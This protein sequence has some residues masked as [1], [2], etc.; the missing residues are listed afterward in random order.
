[1]R[2]T[3]LERR[4]G[5]KQIT[6]TL[7]GQMEMLISAEVCLQMGLRAGDDLTEPR[8]ESLHEAQAR[9][10]C[11]DSAL[12]LLSHRQRT[13][14]ELRD[15]LMQKRSRPEI[16]AETISQLRT[17]GLL[18]TPLTARLNAARAR[19]PLC[20]TSSSGGG[21]VACCCAGASIT[22]LCGKR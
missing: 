21:S 8:I 11:L 13:E 1:M 22:N 4:P 14:S 6:L 5:Q 3:G 2:I 17:A 7:D 20:L 9:K 15:R 18:D 10:S 16:V 19:S 12:R